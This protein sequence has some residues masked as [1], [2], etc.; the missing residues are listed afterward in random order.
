MKDVNGQEAETAIRKAFDAAAKPVVTLDVERYQ[1]FLDNSGM[2]PE[3]KRDFLEA[4]W[5]VIV[6][7]VDLGFG[8]HPLQEVCGQEVCGQNPQER[9]QS[10]AQ[11]DDGVNCGQTDLSKTFNDAPESE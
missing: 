4:L 9:D 1:H 8:V 3:E 5:S 6:T 7:F 11:G 2:N 10:A